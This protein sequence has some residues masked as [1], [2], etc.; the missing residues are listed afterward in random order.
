MRARIFIH[1]Y[2]SLVSKG[3]TMKV[4]GQAAI[5][6]IN[7]LR[8]YIHENGYNTEGGSGKALETAF[9][10]EAFS[11]WV[12]AYAEFIESFP[13]KLRAILMD[14]SSPREDR[15]ESIWQKGLL[16]V[17]NADKL[18]I[19][20]SRLKKALTLPFKESVSIASKYLP[21]QTE[22]DVDIYLTTDPF[23]TGMMK[24]KKVFLSILLAEPTPKLAKGFGHEFHHVGA[25]YWLNKNPQ[26]QTLKGSN[27]HAQM[28]AKIVTYF[29]T[30]GLANCYTSPSAIHIVKGA[31][32][33]NTRVRELEQKMPQL[34]RD[35][36]QLLL[37]ICRKHQPIGDVKEAFRAISLDLS[38]CG[39]P[40]GH[41]LSGRMVEA[42]DKSDDV[43]RKEIINLVKNPF[44]FIDMY[45]MAVNKHSGLNISISK[46][47][48]DRIAEWTT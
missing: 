2:A 39:L 7:Y 30:E 40:A 32:E 25:R 22:I 17:A 20:Q 44:E 29:V 47:V 28:L 46:Q 31:G 26:I 38:G 13:E 11:V 10:D 41:F 48:R 19:L 21:K 27:E 14:L 15:I 1:A 6:L 16:S 12:K 5:V 24:P 18:A 35:L 3:V 37:W 42:M 45:N 23:N 34:R 4:I 43:S 9:R 8:R 36:E 33:H